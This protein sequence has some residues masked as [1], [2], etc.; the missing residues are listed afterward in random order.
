MSI[1]PS[2]ARVAFT[3]PSDLAKSLSYVSLRLGVTK[4]DLVSNLLSEPIEQMRAVLFQVPVPLDTLT[5]EERA[6]VMSGYADM[7]DAAA[8]GAG[9]LADE[10]RGSGGDVHE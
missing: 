2:S 1:S 5:A 6:A 9:G 8:A 3:L 7:L 4:S 10:L